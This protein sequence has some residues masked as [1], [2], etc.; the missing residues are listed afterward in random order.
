MKTEFEGRIL[1]VDP[2]ALVRILEEL[3]AEKVGEYLYRRHI[4]DLEP[5][6]DEAWIRLRTDGQTTTLT[7]KER[8][9]DAVDGMK[10]LEFPVG[11]FDTAH[12]FVERLGRPARWKQENRRIR[13]VLDGIE[14]DIDSWPLIPPYL[15]VEGDSVEA[16]ERMIERLGFSL[17]DMVTFGTKA[18]YENY[19]ID[20][21][22][23][24]DLRFEE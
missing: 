5:G 20:L 9:R 17:S 6:K 13:Y 11:D 18:I 16:V 12:L 4:Y 3:G 15:E 2:E 1:G 19:G 24:P 14:I 8:E 10:E 23:I 21:H 22:A 7:I